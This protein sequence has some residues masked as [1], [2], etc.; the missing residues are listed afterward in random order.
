M[1]I[2]FLPAFLTSAAK[3]GL[4]MALISPGRRIRGASGSASRIS[5]AMGPLTPVS[6]EV[7]RIEGIL[8]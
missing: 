8:K 5:F 6:N 3:S 1:T 4:S 7:V 2:C